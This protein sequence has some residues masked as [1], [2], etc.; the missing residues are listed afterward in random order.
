VHVDVLP[1]DR[2]GTLRDQTVLVRGGRIEALGPAAH[3]GVPVGARRVD[4]RGRTLL[5]GLADLHV[6]LQTPPRL[7]AYLARGVTTIRNLRGRP[8]DVAL[9]ERVTRGEVAGPRV[10]TSGPH[11]DGRGPVF[12]G[13]LRVEGAAEARRAVEAEREAGFDFVKVYSGLDA[14]AYAEGVRTAARLGLPVVGH[15][16]AAV[17]LE[18]VLAAG[19][20]SIEHVEELTRSADLLLDPSRLGELARRVRASG[21]YVCPTLST[22]ARFGPQVLVFQRFHAELVRQLHAAGVGLLVGSDAEGYDEPRSPLLR[23]LEALVGAGLPVEEVLGAATREAGRF[24]G[25]GAGTLA[26]GA[27]ADLVLLEGNPLER[28]DALDAPVGVAVAGRWSGEEELARW[29]QQGRR[30]RPRSEP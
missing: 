5:P 22:Y 26:V 27:P 16:P 11:L 8:A 13:R 4:G 30:S 14:E 9:R 6:H 20:R 25:T 12:P 1:M 24:L 29:R 7:G 21:T 2:A 17:G 15:V 10:F 3:T 18:G 23:E 19:Q 28:L